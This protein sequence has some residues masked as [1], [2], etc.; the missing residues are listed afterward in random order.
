M[1]LGVCHPSVLAEGQ[2]PALQAPA[3]HIEDFWDHGVLV[4]LQIPITLAIR[5]EVDG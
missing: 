1:A 3:A 4:H 2:A 5:G